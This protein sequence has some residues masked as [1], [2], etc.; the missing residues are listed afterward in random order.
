MA[1][2]VDDIVTRMIHLIGRRVDHAIGVRV[3]GGTRMLNEKKRRKKSCQQILRLLQKQP[4]PLGG[5]EG[6]N[7]S[8]ITGSDA[9]R[10]VRSVSMPQLAI[11]TAVWKVIFH[12]IRRK[13][14]NNQG[15]QERKGAPND[16]PLPGKLI[17]LLQH[18]PLM[19]LLAQLDTS[20]LII[21]PSHLFIVQWKMHHGK[22]F[23]ITSLT[24]QNLLT[25]QILPLSYLF[26]TLVMEAP[27]Y[28]LQ[29]GRSHHHWA[30]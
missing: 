10:K 20:P 16:H 29:H 22:N 25:Q 14:N 7:H 3:G 19:H 2:N 4:L 18:L 12:Q 26:H 23:T 21:V 6:V 1:K 24:Y 13:T 17:R 27:H 9:L 5:L 8:E 15:R 30:Q 28:M 11:I